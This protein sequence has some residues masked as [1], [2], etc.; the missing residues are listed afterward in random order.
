[1]AAIVDQFLQGL[2]NL[3]YRLR[4]R[5]FVVDGQ[6]HHIKLSEECWRALEDICSFEGISL[7]QLVEQV[8][9]N[10]RQRSLSVELD[11]FALAYFQAACEP[12]SLHKIAPA[13]FL[14]C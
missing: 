14:P 11:L 2:N 6:P 4:R 13:N 8:A 1:V 12:S 3:S 9:H 5:C 10:G 7:Q